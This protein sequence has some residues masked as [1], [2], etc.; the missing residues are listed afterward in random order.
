MDKNLKKIYYAHSMLHYG[1]ELEHQDILLLERLGYEVIN[2]NHPD[3]EAAYLKNRDF[4][5]FFNLVSM[6]DVLAFRS[7]LGK[8]SAGVAKEID[9]AYSKNIPVIELPTL[10][11]D[12]ILT[13]EETVKYCRP[14]GVKE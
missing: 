10:T 3:N 2:P 13:I 14:K 8:I 1:S 11:Q 5:V 4:N 6:C 9:F 12:R 7:V